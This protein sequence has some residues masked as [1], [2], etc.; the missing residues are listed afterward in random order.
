MC[1]V[2]VSE[3]EGWVRVLKREDRDLHR[4]I[5]RVCLLRRFLEGGFCPNYQFPACNEQSTEMEPTPGTYVKKIYIWN[6]LSCVR[7]K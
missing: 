2:G 5:W 7:K 3:I 6:F 1:E 4:Q